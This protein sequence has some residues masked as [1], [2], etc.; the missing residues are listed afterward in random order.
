MVGAGRRG[1][2]TLSIGTPN[3]VNDRAPT[4]VDPGHRRRRVWSV[5]RAAES[6]LLDCIRLYRLTRLVYADEG[7]RD[8]AVSAQATGFLRGPQTVND[9]VPEKPCAHTRLGILRLWTVR[10]S[11]SSA[12]AT[13][14]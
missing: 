4:T 7:L 1:V 14:R 8:S 5:K 6:E 3:G 12:T 11:M 2:S 13:R 9:F 10:L